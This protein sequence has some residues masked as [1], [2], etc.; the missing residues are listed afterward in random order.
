MCTFTDRDRQ[1]DRQTDTSQSGCSWAWRRRNSSPRVE[2]TEVESATNVR[3]SAARIRSSKRAAPRQCLHGVPEQ[4]WQESQWG[5]DWSIR[6]GTVEVTC[7][8]S[9]CVLAERGEF[10]VGGRE[11]G[12]RSR[13]CDC[14]CESCESGRGNL[15]P[16]G[17]VSWEGASRGD[18]SLRDGRGAGRCAG[19]MCL[20]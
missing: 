15:P 20:T 16:K 19:H 3:E 4:L 14:Q 5:P 11:Q 13:A 8:E 18:G 12:R 10:Q 9:L 6:R 1:T 17:N 2:W 7:G